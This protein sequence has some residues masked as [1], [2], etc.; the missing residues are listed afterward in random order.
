MDKKSKKLLIGVSKDS[1]VI[2]RINKNFSK[3]VSHMLNINKE[4]ADLLDSNLSLL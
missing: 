3:D 4:Q 1:E 2:I